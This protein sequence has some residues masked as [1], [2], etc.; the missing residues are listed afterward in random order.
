MTD[1]GP[2]YIVGLKVVQTVGGPVMRVVGFNHLMAMLQC[3]WTGANGEI[4]QKY[5]HRSHLSVWRKGEKVS[6]THG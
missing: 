1:R 4:C 6:H 3:E 5:F 2:P